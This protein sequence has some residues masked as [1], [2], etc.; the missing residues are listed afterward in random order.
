MTLLIVNDEDF[1]A[2]S[3][4]K[5]I[6]WVQYGIEEALAV[7][8]AEHAK[9]VIERQKIDIMLCDIEMPGENGLALLRWVRE[10][11]K[12]IECIFLTCHASFT[13]AQEAI[14]L[15]CQDYLLIPAKYEDIGAIV[16]KVVNR[17]KIRNEE[18]RY[19]E[20]GKSMIQEKVNHAV[21]ERGEKKTHREITEE[22]EEYV[23]KNIGSAELSVNTMADVFFLHPVY[24]NRIFKK[25]KGMSISQYIIG[26]RMKLAEDLLRSG[27]LSAA[28]VAEQ[29]GYKNYSS[30]NLVFKKYFGY[31]P[32]QYKK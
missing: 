10:N 3:M 29:V 22:I 15:G 30:F 11:Q 5:D 12:E 8:S 24:L 26:E 21:E 25:E 31:A 20:Y 17:I 16:L 9:S 23:V 27:K 28:T 18:K 7:Y 13:Y 14:G 4:K 2:E 6:D 19:Q 32:T 1:T